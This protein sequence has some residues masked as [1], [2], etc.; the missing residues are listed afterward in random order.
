[1]AGHTE[2]RA[3]SGGEDS[4]WT[5]RETMYEL[6]AR[7]GV[8]EL[9]AIAGWLYAEMLEAGMTAVGEFHYVHGALQDRG[10]TVGLAMSEAL[11]RA[12]EAAGIRMTLLPVFY[13][14]GGFG[15]ELSERQRRFACGGVEGFLELFN[16]L[17]QEAT[18]RPWLRIGLAPHSL[19]AVNHEELTALLE[20]VTATAAAA[21]IHIHVAEQPQEVEECIAALG[22]PPVRWLLDHFPVGSRWCLVHATHLRE[23]ERRDLATSGAVVG[24]CPTTE[25][26]LGDGLFPLV[27]FLQ[28]GGKIGIGSDSHVTVDGAEELRW[29]EYGQRWFHRRRNLVA[30]REPATRHVG[31]RLLDLCTRGGAHALDQPI[32]GLRPGAQADLVVL[33]LDHPGLVGHGPDTLL[34][35]WVFHAGRG[36]IRDVMVGGQW[37]VRGG[38]HVRRAELLAAFRRVVEGWRTAR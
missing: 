21:P 11:L 6:A 4:F 29:L 28:E 26:N 9:Q 32:G 22:A 31:R 27:E 15:R 2:H 36:A 18:A 10:G 23:D 25:A 1:M 16:A 35:A 7:V 34:D 14:H 24:L 3:P 37:V 20:A 12:A 17:E 8:G 19:R 30:G 5:W 13:A 33:D 38:Q